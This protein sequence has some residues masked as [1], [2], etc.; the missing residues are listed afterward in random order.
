MHYSDGQGVAAGYQSV[1]C[2]DGRRVRRA[3]FAKELCLYLCVPFFWAVDLLAEASLEHQWV[4]TACSLDRRTRLASSYCPSLSLLLG[5]ALALD[6]LPMAL[7]S[8][9]LLS[10]PS[11]FTY[12]HLWNGAK[13]SSTPQ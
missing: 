3:P 1:C 13:T 5:A 8:R 2:N 9:I 10:I 12:L 4:T 7:L 11:C 6:T